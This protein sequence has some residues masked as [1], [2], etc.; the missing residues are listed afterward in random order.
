YY[1]DTG[2]RRMRFAVVPYGNAPSLCTRPGVEWLSVRGP[3]LVGLPRIDGVVADLRGE[4]PSEW[5]SFLADCTI[6]RIP[7]YHATHAHEMITGRV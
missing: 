3:D 7:V 6:H 4:L 5:E 1:I 2:L